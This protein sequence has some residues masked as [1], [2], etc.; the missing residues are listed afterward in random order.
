MNV[1]MRPGFW[2]DRGRIRLGEYLRTL[3]REGRN[4]Q[5]LACDS[6][7]GIARRFVLK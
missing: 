5:L 7:S 2:V 6:F 4:L 1:P 3:K